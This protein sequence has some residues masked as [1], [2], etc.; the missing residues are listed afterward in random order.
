[1]SIMTQAATRAIQEKAQ[2]ILREAFA[3]DPLTKN[4]SI[5]YVGG[6]IGMGRNDCTL[7]FQFVD[8]TVAPTSILGSE[9]TN[10]M[11]RNG[12]AGVGATVLFGGKEYTVIKA[13]QKKYLA[14]CKENGV[15]YTLPFMGCSLAP[16][17]VG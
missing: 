2:K 7:K 1:M 15:N 6:S 3:A 17:K 12:Y 13:R 14:T 8:S 4:L 9:L 16:A 10:D 11:V 5:S